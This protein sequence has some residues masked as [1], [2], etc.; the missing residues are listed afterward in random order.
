MRALRTSRLKSG[1]RSLDKR[2]RAYLKDT[3]ARKRDSVGRHGYGN[4]AAVRNIGKAEHLLARIARR[5]CEIR[6]GRGGPYIGGLKD[7]RRR[8]SDV[9]RGA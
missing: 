4:I 2:A 8:N 5:P 3:L 6:Y 7:S 1:S 9:E